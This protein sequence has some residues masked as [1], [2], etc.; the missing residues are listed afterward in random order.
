MLHYFLFFSIFL[1]II[2]FNFAQDVDNSYIDLNIDEL[3]MVRIHEPAKE[4]N[5]CTTT[6][7]NFTKSIIHNNR[8]ENLYELIAIY[9]SSHPKAKARKSIKFHLY[10]NSVLVNNPVQYY[11]RYNIDDVAS[12]E[13]DWLEATNFGSINVKLQH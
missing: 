5:D 3:M 10:N 7:M 13:V 12:I 1:G 9:L 8:I 2:H 4:S 11:L 6:S